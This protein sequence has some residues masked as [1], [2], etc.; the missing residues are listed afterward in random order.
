MIAAGEQL[1]PDEAFPRL[2]KDLL[3]LIETVGERRAVAEGE[4]LNRAGE[5]AQEF[6]VVV[7]GSLAAYENHGTTTQRLI[8]AVGRGGFLGGAHLMT[9]Q[10][11]YVTSVAEEDGEVIAL[12][13]PQLRA[14]LSSDQHL[15]D[16][17][18]GAFVARRAMLI[19]LAA[20]LRLVGSRLA[21][22]TRRLR[23]FLAR[24]RIPHA[25]VD[26]ETDEQADG[27]LR[28][29]GVAPSETPLLLGGA[30]ALRN[31]TNAE[32]AK[33]LNLRPARTPVRLADVVIVGAG[34]AGLGAAVYAA[35]EGLSCVLVDSTAVGGQ[36]S[37]SAR[38][39][40]YL[41]FPAGISGGE[42]TERAALQADRFG[43]RSAVP[44]AATRLVGENGHH[45]VEL[46]GGGEC[47]RGRTVLVATGARYR[48]LAVGRLDE[49]EGAGV[50]YAATEVEAQA[51]Q[52]E[53]V[54]VVGGANSAGQA[55]IFLAD[56]GCHVHLVVRRRDLGETMSRYLLDRIE[57][58]PAIH[59][60]LG[61]QVRDLHGR[62]S[63]ESVTVDDDD[64]PIPARA[65]FVFIGADPC[66]AWLDGS[67][68][69]DA[70]GFLLTGQDL[71]LT[72]LDPLGL[73]P[74]RG[75]A[76]LA[77]ET[78]RPGVFATGDVRSG[79]MKRVASA[80]GEGA[81]AVRMVH[82]YLRET[83]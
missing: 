42:L 31:P 76:P 30:L 23:D 71:Q 1:E 67:L 14:I 66:T 78:S 6:C 50:F 74:L 26:L 61:A 43:A 58:R 49:F 17:I 40:N 63:L 8:G 10:P 65:L 25:L 12:T 68:A 55:A 15:G 56:R 34:P 73:G 81:A 80:V 47:L 13:M 4:V 7:R 69:T 18:L 37:T 11:A 64:A 32:V 46:D 60:R 28:E 22:E 35:S 20:G 41:G 57:A 45:L 70:D 36:A 3:A 77:L 16:L 33:A 29:L 38:I 51:C 54:V 48:R 24:N 79:S 5:V 27:L 62:G 53:P 52:G 82:Q 2:P 59:V 39:E 19:G 83:L 9:G 75:R 21:P 44:V 72:H